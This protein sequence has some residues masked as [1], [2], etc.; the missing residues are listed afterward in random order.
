MSRKVDI[1]DKVD[2][3]ERTEGEM[4]H[5]DQKEISTMSPHV[6][7]SRSYCADA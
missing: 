1:R 5:I 3:A 4:A 6:I 7:S 2:R